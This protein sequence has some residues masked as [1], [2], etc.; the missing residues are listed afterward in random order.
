LEEIGRLKC[1]LDEKEEELTQV[2]QELAGKKDEYQVC[3]YRKNFVQFEPT[4]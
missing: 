2:I 4:R 3:T 1:E